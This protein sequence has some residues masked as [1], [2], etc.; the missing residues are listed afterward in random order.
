MGGSGGVGWGGV[1]WLEWM[2][3]SIFLGFLFLTNASDIFRVKITHP[4]TV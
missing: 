2:C 3:E 1:G 4:N